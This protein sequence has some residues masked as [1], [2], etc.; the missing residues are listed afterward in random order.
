MVQVSRLL[1]VK[2]SQNG[3]N[4]DVDAELSDLVSGASV[5]KFSR[6]NVAAGDVND[7]LEMISRDAFE[8]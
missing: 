6:Q 5:M 3:P 1:V 2:I 7:V 8:L 4:Y